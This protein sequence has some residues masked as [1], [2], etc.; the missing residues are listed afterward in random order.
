M[1]IFMGMTL[2]AAIVAGIVLFKE[3]CD[4]K[5]REKIAEEERERRAIEEQEHREMMANIKRQTQLMELLRQAK[6]VG[7]KET[8][9]DILNGNYDGKLPEEL[10]NGM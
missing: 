1:G 7:D 4:K 6:L 2:I 8:E 5:D 10:S 3:Y 9:A